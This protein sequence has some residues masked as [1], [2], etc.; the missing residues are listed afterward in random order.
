MGLTL[1]KETTNYG[2][3]VFQEVLENAMGGFILDTTGLPA[4]KLVLQ[5]TPVKFDESTRVAQI[6]IC[7]EIYENADAAAVDYKVKKGHFFSVGNYLAAAV[8]GA[9]YAITA[10]NTTNADYDT[11]TVGTTLG[12]LSTGDIVFKSSATGAAAAALAVTPKGLLYQDT[13]VE[14]NSPC[15]VVLRGTVYARRVANG[16]HSAVRTALP[17]I[18]FSESY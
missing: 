3:V 13:K 15:A 1:K 12:A 11:L 9:A 14:T 2:K 10:I 7:A 8:G 5:G 16:L 18:I 17:L 6:L 4:D